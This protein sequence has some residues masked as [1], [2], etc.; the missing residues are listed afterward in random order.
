MQ[1]LKPCSTQANSFA[2]LCVDFPS[3]PVMTKVTGPLFPGD[4]R[5]VAIVIALL[6]C[7]LDGGLWLRHCRAK[8]KGWK[9][10]M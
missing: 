7:L 6:V 4:R 2:R 5:A 10:K 3:P 8:F 9:D 1:V